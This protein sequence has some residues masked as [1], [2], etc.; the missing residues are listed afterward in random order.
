LGI[1]PRVLV[2]ERDGERRN[3]SGNSSLPPTVID[4]LFHKGGVDYD[5]DYS[6]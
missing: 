5:D 3:P 6:L 1:N 2:L 4:E